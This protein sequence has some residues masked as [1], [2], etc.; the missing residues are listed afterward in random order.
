MEAQLFTLR[1]SNENPVSECPTFKKK[2][3]FFRSECLRL[4]FALKLMINCRLL[5]WL[6]KERGMTRFILS[7]RTDNH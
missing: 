4:V 2:V 5:K 3:N 1:V 6:V 7:T